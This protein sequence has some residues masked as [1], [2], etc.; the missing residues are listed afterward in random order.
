M[1][2]TIFLLMLSVI[3]IFNTSCESGTE[4][5]DQFGKRDYEWQLDTLSNQFPRN[6]YALIYGANPTNIW[7]TGWGPFKN[8]IIKYDGMSWEAELN[9]PHK[10]YFSIYGISE[11]EIYYGSDDGQIVHYL[12]GNY[13]LLP[14][15]Q[16][17]QYWRT[18]R[19]AGFFKQGDVLFAIGA[20]K[21][22]ITYDLWTFILKYD[23]SVWEYFEKPTDKGIYV[24]AYEDNFNKKCLFVRNDYNLEGAD[25][26]KVI[27]FDGENL[28]E[29]FSNQND[30]QGYPT[31]SKMGSTLYVFC[32]GIMYVFNG[33]NL[34][35]LKDFSTEKYIP[36]R[37]F[38]RNE[39]DFFFRT[40][41]GFA[42]YNGEDVKII[43]STNEMYGITDAA[44]FENEVMFIGF[45]YDTGLY[46]SLKG[47][48]K[49]E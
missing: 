28:K 21:D 30:L 24:K 10:D 26:N 5:K 46:Y 48:L 19:Y 43:Y 20:A 9:H 42:H 3:I 2:E 38:G 14:I 39:N 45:T 11:N 44:V 33:E 32:S 23:G 41:D 12:N 29:I 17:D 49:T 22:T 27:L 25:T 40:E 31:I 8:T 13:S 6:S 36:A 18:F 1:K 35:Q 16:Q 15:P 47:K 7:A 37:I 4:P 34:D